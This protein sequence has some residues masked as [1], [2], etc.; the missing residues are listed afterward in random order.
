MAVKIGAEDSCQGDSAVPHSIG[1]AQSR[2]AWIDATIR[3]LDRLESTLETIDTPGQRRG[4]LQ[5]CVGANTLVG[6]Q[7]PRAA[8]ASRVA[9]FS[10]DG[11]TV[12]DRGWRCVQDCVHRR[13]RVHL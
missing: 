5:D 10:T 8:S 2:K 11:G 4:C 1:N 3:E 12:S 7:C 13:G 6:G 9:L